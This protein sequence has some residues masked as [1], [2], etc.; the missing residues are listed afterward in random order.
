MGLYLGGNILGRIF[1]FEVGRIFKK[2]YFGGGRGQNCM[3]GQN[4]MI[5]Y[6]MNVHMSLLASKIKHLKIMTGDKKTH[7]EQHDLHHHSSVN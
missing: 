6:L 3:S 7:F 5:C 1:A 4:C 2:A